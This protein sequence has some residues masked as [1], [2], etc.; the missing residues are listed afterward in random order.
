MYKTYLRFV[1]SEKTKLNGIVENLLVVTF[2]SSLYHFNVFIN[3][4]FR[5]F[6]TGTEIQKN[7][8]QS[9]RN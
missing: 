7:N 3:K 9:K 4:L 1:A 8:L 2:S 5:I 6:P